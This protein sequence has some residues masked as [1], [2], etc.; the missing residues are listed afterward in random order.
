VLRLS[1]KRNHLKT[2]PLRPPQMRQIQIHRNTPTFD[3]RSQ[4]FW[5]AAVHHLSH[6]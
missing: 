1:T 4:T 3:D 2:F 6:G 5:S